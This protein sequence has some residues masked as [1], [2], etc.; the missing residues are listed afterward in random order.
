MFSPNIYLL[1]G[2]AYRHFKFRR[3]LYRGWLDELFATR[4]FIR[5][6]A[7]TKA[8]LTNKVSNPFFFRNKRTDILGQ[9]RWGFLCSIIE[10]NA[11][12]KE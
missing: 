6:V 2:I 1:Q 11:L 9:I 3:F 10:V 4:I 5:I 12:R 8:Y 7:S